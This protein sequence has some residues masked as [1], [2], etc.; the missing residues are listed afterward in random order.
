[1]RSTDETAA[2]TSTVIIL[3]LALAHKTESFFAF[4]PRPRPAPFGNEYGLH[5]GSSIIVL[6]CT[7][8]V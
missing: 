4:F 5:L 1:M 3:A 8:N 7:V 6:Y 2:R